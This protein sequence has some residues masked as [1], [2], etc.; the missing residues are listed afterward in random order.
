MMEEKKNTIMNTL[1]IIQPSIY[2]ITNITK[3]L[4]ADC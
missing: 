1:N 3:Q 4:P 2:K